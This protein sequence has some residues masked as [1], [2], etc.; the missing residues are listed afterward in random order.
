MYL[1]LAHK[2]KLGDALGGFNNLGERD[3]NGGIRL[4]ICFEDRTGSLDRLDMG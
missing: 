2:W 3:L 1:S 4:W